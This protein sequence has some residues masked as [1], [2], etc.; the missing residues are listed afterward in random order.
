MPIATIAMN[1]V[2]IST[3]NTAFIFTITPK[4]IAIIPTR[5]KKN[6][7]VTGL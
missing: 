2:N 7:I 1:V 3:V 6:P 4:P 5:M